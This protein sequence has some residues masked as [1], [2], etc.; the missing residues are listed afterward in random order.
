RASGVRDALARVQTIISFAGFLDDSAAWAD[1]LLPDH[2]ALETEMALVPAVSPQP[3]VTIS[4][5]FIQP[6]YDT[7]AVE[8][9]LAELARKLDLEYQRVTPKD[10]LQPLIP[11]DR[12]YEEA[13]REGGLWLKPE[14]AKAVRLAGQKL[15]FRMAAF[16]GDPSQ[17]P[18][19]FQPYLSLEFHD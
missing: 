2:H 5:P 3:A 10:L 13:A 6:L 1:L 17:F 19:Q 4:Q 12:T 7:R 9:T 14:S 18:L 8:H 11:A 15:E 16:A